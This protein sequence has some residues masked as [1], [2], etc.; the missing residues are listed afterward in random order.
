M[1]EKEAALK[2]E[3]ARIAGVFIERLKKGMRL[4]SDPTVIYGL[5]EKLRRLHPHARPADRQSLQHLHARGPAA[6]ADRAARARVAGRRRAARGQPARCISSPP[7]SATARTTSRARWRST[8]RAV[9]SYLARLRSQARAAAAEA[10]GDARSHEPRQV[11]HPGRHRGRGQVDRR[12]RS[13]AR[14]CGRAG[15]SVLATREPGGTP[16]AE[17]VRQIVLERGTESRVA[18]DRDAADVRRPRAARGAT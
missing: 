7:G 3:R 12:P 15:C 11:H 6:D 18:G 8:I 9:Q 17:R 13:C 4:Q 14:A 16:L 1:V 5:G 2:S 10:G